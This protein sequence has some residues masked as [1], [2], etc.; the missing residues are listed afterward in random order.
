MYFTEKHSENQ[1]SFLALMSKLSLSNSCL[2]SRDTLPQSSGGAPGTI[3]VSARTHR[4]HSQRS[5][6][7]R[8]TSNRTDQECVLTCVSYDLFP[9]LVGED[10]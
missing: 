2:T 10:V 5:F 4:R 7:N 8:A 3:A 9:G 1:R 6:Q